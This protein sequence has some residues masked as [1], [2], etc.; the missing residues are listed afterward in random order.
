MAVLGTWVVGACCWPLWPWDTV[1]THT[2]TLGVTAG[3]AG[4]RRGGGS[5]KESIHPTHPPVRNRGAATA[6]RV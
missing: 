2:H 3:T 1:G 5:A 4:A 6:K